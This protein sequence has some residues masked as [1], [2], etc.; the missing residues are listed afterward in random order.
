MKAKASLDSNRT[1][2]C[3]SYTHQAAEEM[4]TAFTLSMRE[5]PSHRRA[6]SQ[7]ELAMRKIGKPTL[8]E[9]YLTLY[10][11]RQNLEKAAFFYRELKAGYEE[12]WDHLKEKGIGHVYISR[13]STF[14][15]FFRNRIEPVYCHDKRDFIWFAFHEFPFILQHFFKPED[16]LDG[17][18]FPE[19]DLN[20]TPLCHWVK[21]YKAILGTIPL[22]QAPTIYQRAQHIMGELRKIKSA[23]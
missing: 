9:E 4:A 15:L 21:R 3:L 13:E 5:A 6:I 17:N 8:F 16:C 14:Q 1:Y 2:S 10:N 19:A 23:N 11:M 20:K 22:A 18:V 7:L 12:I